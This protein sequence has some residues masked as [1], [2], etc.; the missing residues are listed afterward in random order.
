MGIDAEVRPLEH[1]GA[2]RYESPE[3]ALESLGRMVRPADEREAAA[4]ERYVAE[5]L[6]ETTGADGRTQWQQE[7]EISVRWAFLAWDKS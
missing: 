4:L 6:V 5:H 2:S 7:P 3:A 1:A